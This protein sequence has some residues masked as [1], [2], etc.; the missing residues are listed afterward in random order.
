MPPLKNN[1]SIIKNNKS[2]FIESGLEKRR[3]RFQSRNMK[4]EINYFNKLNE[5]Q[6]DCLLIESYCDIIIK[7]DSNEIHLS[8]Y[9]KKEII[10]S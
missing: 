5:Y 3:K 6:S 2:I 7:N 4:N 1:I 8:E 10:K 9:F